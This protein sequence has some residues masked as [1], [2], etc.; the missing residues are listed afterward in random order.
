MSKFV[1]FMVHL[2]LALVRLFWM[3]VIA[4]VLMIVGNLWSD[5]V[6][7]I[8]LAFAITN[9]IVAF[10]A[11]IRMQRMVNYRSD[12]DPEF[13]E[14]MDK[15]Q[16]NPKAFL[17]ETMEK[18]EMNK[19][20]HAEELLKLSDEDLFETIF[21]QNLDIAEQAEDGEKEI[22]QFTGA[23]RTVFALSLFDSEVQ[24]G[25][26]CQFFV[27]SS[28]GAAPYVSEALEA[29]GAMKHRDLFD[30][31]ITSNQIDLTDLSSFIIFSARGFKRQTQRYDFDSFDEKYYELPALQDY[32]IAYI[33]NNIN[34]F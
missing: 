33:R 13:N 6:F 4:V 10:L 23:R 20:L 29:V 31:F 32:V 14:M 7:G 8:G 2:F 27:N 18:Q 26:L 5:F 19:N 11:A 30:T 21:L 34:E 25:G 1:M 15:L 22:E 9:V 12:D 16:T 24:N 3:I 17:A 28:R